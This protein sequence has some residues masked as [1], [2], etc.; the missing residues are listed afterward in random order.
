MLACVIR[1][2]CSGSWRGPRSGRRGHGARAGAGER[3]Q[4][5]HRVPDATST[6]TRT[7]TPADHTTITTGIF[8][9]YLFITYYVSPLNF[10]SLSV[11][12]VFGLLRPAKCETNGSMVSGGLIMSNIKGLNGF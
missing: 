3:G 7:A 1:G 10:F 5:T 4:R 9:F 11:S 8:D 2:W 12:K 6:C